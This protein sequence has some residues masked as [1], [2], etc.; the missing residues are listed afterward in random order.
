MGSCQVSTVLSSRKVYTERTNSHPQTHTF[1]STAKMHHPQAKLSSQFVFGWNCVH[2]HIILGQHRRVKH[3]SKRA[4]STRTRELGQRKNSKIHQLFDFFFVSVQ[5]EVCCLSTHHRPSVAHL[6]A[7][8]IFST[9]CERL[10]DRL[11]C[12]KSLY[13][14]ARA[15]PGFFAPPCQC[16]CTQ[17]PS[18]QNYSEFH[19]LNEKCKSAMHYKIRGRKRPILY[20]MMRL[21]M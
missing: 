20:V 3:E 21:F 18:G 1:S 14:P 11:K 2:D 17:K 9:H 10:L 6:F 8:P 19:G 7:I 13:D 15:I 4:S 12:A 16:V 5:C